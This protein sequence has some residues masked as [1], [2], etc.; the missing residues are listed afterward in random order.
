MLIRPSQSHS[1]ISGLFCTFKRFTT[2]FPNA[3]QPFYVAQTPRVSREAREARD[4]N[5]RKKCEKQKTGEGGTRS[6]LPGRWSAVSLTLY[7]SLSSSAHHSLLIIAI[8][9]CVSLENASRFSRLCFI[10]YPFFLC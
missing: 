1:I 10:F 2:F 6:F 4:I 8:Y 5:R 7:D 3:F 9:M